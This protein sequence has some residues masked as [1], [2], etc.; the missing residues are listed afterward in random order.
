MILTELFNLEELV[1][2]VVCD[3]RWLGNKDGGG[4]IIRM[5]AAS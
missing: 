2:E 3:E 4:L 5:V 1:V